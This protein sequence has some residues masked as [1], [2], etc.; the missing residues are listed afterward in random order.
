ML[1]ESLELPAIEGLF[2][3]QSRGA[4]GAVGGNVPAYPLFQAPGVNKNKN[5]MQEISVYCSTTNFAHSMP[6]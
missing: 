3:T 6:A 5:E 4:K 1:S 2:P